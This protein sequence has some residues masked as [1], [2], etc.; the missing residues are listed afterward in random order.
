MLDSLCN[1]RQ[2][3]ML[4]CYS[5]YKVKCQVLSSNR[6]LFYTLFKMFLLTGSL[7][8]E[9]FKGEF[10]NALQHS[11]FIYK[12]N[13]LIKENP[14]Q[15]ISSVSK[16]MAEK[17]SEAVIDVVNECQ[18]SVEEQLIL[19]DES[20]AEGTFKEVSSFRVIIVL[21]IMNICV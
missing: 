5:Q 15:N 14:P 4:I 18:V 20:D 17:T 13:N 10:T 3:R 19:F 8:D 21:L 16:T 7:D 12:N 6:N 2:C 1:D 9:S 11:L